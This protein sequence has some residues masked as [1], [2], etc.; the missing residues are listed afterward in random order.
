[1]NNRINE[2]AKQATYTVKGVNGCTWGETVSM[3]KLAELII[4]DVVNTIK[5][6]QPTTQDFEWAI[7]NNYDLEV[8][9]ERT[10]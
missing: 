1:M 4:R 5:R 3:E 6:T 7:L 10:N 2:L 8:N 9:D